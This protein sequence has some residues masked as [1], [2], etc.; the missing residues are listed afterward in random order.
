M[1]KSFRIMF[2]LVVVGMFLSVF[3]G[4]CGPKPADPVVTGPEP[5]IPQEAPKDLDKPD[6]KEELRTGILVPLDTVTLALNFKQ[7]QSGTYKLVTEWKN[8]VEFEG[9]LAKDGQ[10]EGGSTG[11]TLE[12]TFSQRVESVDDGGN[13]TLAITIKSLKFKSIVKNTVRLDFDSGRDKDKNN[14]LAKLI[15][16]GYKIRL[17]Q[18]GA[19]LGVLDTKEVLAAVRGN[20]AGHQFGT[21]LLKTDVVMNRHA[22]TALPKAG[23]NQLA[24]GQDWSSV[25]SVIFGPM[26]HR[27][28]ERIYVLKEIKDIGDKKMCVI[29]MNAIPTSQRAEGSNIDEATESISKMFDNIDIYNGSLELDLADG[30][31]EKFTENLTS[32]WII[33]DP[34]AQPNSETEPDSVKMTAIR[35]HKLERIDN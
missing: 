13:A 28:F 16:K 3:A 35:T 15:G 1:M 7:G 4:G 11:D 21:A 8:S 5:T 22:I 19:V 12:M 6:V 30:T 14:P 32:E 29:E 23:K 20:T 18:E 24:S 33:V 9:P 26:G 27:S 25:K 10:F 31:V 2:L 34:A 17:S